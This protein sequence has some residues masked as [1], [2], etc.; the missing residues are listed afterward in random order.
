MGSFPV[1][2]LASTVQSIKTLRKKW[3]KCKEGGVCL[4]MVN[5]PGTT[6]PEGIAHLLLARSFLKGDANF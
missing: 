6:L 3:D 4:L 5:G 1:G 2:L